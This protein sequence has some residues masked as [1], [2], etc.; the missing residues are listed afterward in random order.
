MAAG[1]GPAWPLLLPVT[2][3]GQ[4]DQSLFH[5]GKIWGLSRASRCPWCLLA[6]W[7]LSARAGLA[8]GQGSPLAFTLLRR[9]GCDPGLDGRMGCWCARSPPAPDRFLAWGPRRKAPGWEWEF[10]A[11][12]EELCLSFPCYEA[13]LMPFLE[14]L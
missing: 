2:A 12:S 3:G 14:V 5:L 11:N 9:E 4:R 13:M 7:A 10:G 8:L 1:L 6:V